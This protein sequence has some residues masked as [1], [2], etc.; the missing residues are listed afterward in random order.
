M[1]DP[2]RWAIIDGTATEDEVADAIWTIVS[3]RFP[4]LT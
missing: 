2:D 3:I 1:E 4:D